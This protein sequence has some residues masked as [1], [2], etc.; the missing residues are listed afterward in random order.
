MK[1]HGKSID[2]NREIVSLI[3]EDVFGMTMLLRD[4]I[5]QSRV[6]PFHP[7]LPRSI[8]NLTLYQNLTVS[9]EEQDFLCVFPL[10]N[11]PSAACSSRWDY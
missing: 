2:C 11:S 7:R 9:C 1:V 8:V 5:K 6:N 10:K 3:V 4:D